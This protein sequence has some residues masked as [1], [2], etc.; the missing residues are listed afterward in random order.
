[1]KPTI[2]QTN[3]AFDKIYPELVALVKSYV[4]GIFEGEVMSDLQTTATK[5]K[6]VQMIEDGLTAALNVPPATPPAA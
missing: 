3:A 1:M 2:A 6:L 4:Q 5:A